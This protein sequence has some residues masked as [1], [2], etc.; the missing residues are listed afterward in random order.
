MPQAL[1]DH[2]YDSVFQ[3]DEN[4]KSDE[5]KRISLQNRKV[6]TLT[7]LRNILFGSIEETKA[8]LLN[9]LTHLHG[10][11]D[12]KAIKKACIILKTINSITSKIILDKKEKIQLLNSIET[13]KNNLDKLD[14]DSDKKANQAING[15]ISLISEDSQKDGFEPD[16]RVVKYIDAGLGG[17]KEIGTKLKHLQDLDVDHL[18]KIS[19]I[20]NSLNSL[21]S[22]IKEQDVILE[23]IL[24]K[25]SV[26]NKK[27]LSDNEIFSEINNLTKLISTE[28]TDDNTYLR[29]CY[30]IVNVKDEN[31]NMADVKWLEENQLKLDKD[32][33]LLFRQFL[34]PKVAFESGNYT[35]FINSASNVQKVIEAGIINDPTGQEKNS[36]F[37]IGSLKRA[38]YYISY[39]LNT[40]DS[41]FVDDDNPCGFMLPVEE[42]MKAHYFT[43]KRNMSEI[44]VYDKPHE[45]S[46]LIQQVKD[47]VKLFDEMLK[48]IDECYTNWLKEAR[49][50]QHDFRKSWSDAAHEL[51]ITDFSKRW[52]NERAPVFRDKMHTLF[53]L[54][55]FFTDTLWFESVSEEEIRKAQAEGYDEEFIK[56]KDFIE[57]VYRMNKGEF[58]AAVKRS[59]KFYQSIIPDAIDFLKNAK[60]EIPIVNAIF[61]ASRKRVLYW[62]KYFEKIG[63]RPRIYYYKSA[64]ID[65]GVMEAFSKCNTTTNFKRKVTGIRTT[66]IFNSPFWGL[67]TI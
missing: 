36:K 67:Q 22:N 51:I 66:K 49:G 17:L 25:K 24:G 59:K 7:E 1:D 56:P 4:L 62:E 28:L 39:K 53:D 32:I 12:I 50:I 15:L 48:D 35:T 13:E 9:A 54:V 18:S 65:K 33:K 41:R 38:L 34:I 55:D 19:I 43:L 31:Q 27:K 61:L 44:M 45:D 8:R 63:Y 37:R 46:D 42:V 64:T 14:I 29:L 23:N 47:D 57:Q 21:E 58:I 6:V 10:S 26:F 5:N 52:V 60:F 16:K 3:I 30:E 40:S 20:Y 11:E 2:S